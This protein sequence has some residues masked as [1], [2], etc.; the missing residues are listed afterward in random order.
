MF[1]TGND[2]SFKS[3]FF[4]SIPFSRILKKK[5]AKKKQEISEKNN[6][7]F[8][9]FKHPK[10]NFNFSPQKFQIAGE[11][12]IHDF[13]IEFLKLIPEQLLSYSFHEQ[14]RIQIIQSLEQKLKTI[15]DYLC[16]SLSFGSDS[17]MFFTNY[18]IRVFECILSWIKFGIPLSFV[19]KFKFYS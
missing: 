12:D 8:S 14:V 6:D 2:L 13:V 10:L 4:F 1:D 3:T 11:I 9:I 5:F 16:A 7:L 19:S 15:L 18:K 17:S